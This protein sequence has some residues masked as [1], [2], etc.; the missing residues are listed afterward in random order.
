MYKITFYIFIKY[1]NLIKITYA[2][3]DQKLANYFWE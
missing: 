3:I 1:G 2:K